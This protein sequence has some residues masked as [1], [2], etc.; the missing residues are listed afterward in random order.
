MK[1]YLPAT[2]APIDAT[3]AATESAPAVSGS[4]NILLVEDEPFVR[5]YAERLLG[6]LG[7][8]VLAAANGT[9]AMEI[10]HRNSDIDLLFTDMVMPGGMNGGELAQAARQ[11]DPSQGPVHFRLHR[12]RRLSSRR[13]AGRYH[14]LTK[15]YRRQSWLQSFVRS[16]RNA[17]PDV[18]P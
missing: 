15:P 17:D 3:E 18:G 10:L 16:R 14:L 5:D 8:H 4:E 6:S 7:Y 13:A 12:C 11:C 1:L 2:D 9:D